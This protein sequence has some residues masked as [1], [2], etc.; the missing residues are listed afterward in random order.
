MSRNPGRKPEPYDL[1]SKTGDPHS[2]LWIG[3]IIFVGTWT[4]LL[5]I[6][7]GRGSIPI[8]FDP[9]KIQVEM[10]KRFDE[11]LQK[12]E[13]LLKKYIDSPHPNLAFRDQL[14]RSE[15]TETIH[16]EPPAPQA[17]VSL[18]IPAVVSS[19]VASAPPEHRPDALTPVNPTSNSAVDAEKPA[20][21]PSVSATDRQPVPVQIKPPA[22]E[23]LATAI[24]AKGI[25]TLRANPIPSRRMAENIVGKLKSKGYDARMQTRMISGKGIWYEITVENIK[26]R[27]EANAL[28]ADLRQENMESTVR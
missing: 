3:M 8:L 28:M 2:Y 21:P 16:L 19:P 23:V 22:P 14:T 27:T 15:N 24:P 6:L 12:K 18:P 4:F 10:A 13:A 25:I 5:G 11:A 26:T 17:G 20:I 1:R 9:K 7:V